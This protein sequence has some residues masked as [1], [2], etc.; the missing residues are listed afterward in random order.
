MKKEGMQEMQ[1][2]G[3][4]VPLQVVPLPD[5]KYRIIGGEHRWKAA[6]EAEIDQ[7]PCAVLTEERWQDED[8]QKFV[9][10]RLN[11]IHGDLD[12][13]RFLN[14]YNE[15]V[16]RYGKESIQQLMGFVDTRQF[17][18]LVGDVKKGVKKSLPKDMQED[19]EKAADE[20]ETVEDLES[21][22]QSLYNKYGETMTQSFMVFTFGR[23]EHIFVTMDRPMKKAMDRVLL[24]CQE[25]GENINDVMAPIVKKCAQEAALR[26]NPPEEEA[27]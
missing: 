16:E 1:E 25:T 15:M 8:F 5:G 2:Q 26:L 12:P 9:T 3:C 22:I 13:A 7:V 24:L 23:Q 11:V 4:T 18:K 6:M 17:Q 19:F 20:A 21:V 27:E 14:L 10:V